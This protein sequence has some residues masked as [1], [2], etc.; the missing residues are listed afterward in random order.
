M[1][2]IKGPIYIIVFLYTTET[3]PVTPTAASA[4]PT[5]STSQKTGINLDS[6]IHVACEHDRWNI[7]V[8]MNHLKQLYPGIQ[9]D[10]IYL[11]STTCKG[12][13]ES[14]VLK[15]QQSLQTCSTTETVCF[16]L[17]FFHEAHS[18]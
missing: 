12:V 9:E 6:A 4:I 5:Q 17:Y 2:L 7:S 3:R 13:T 1:S 8:D 11:G 16:Q 14:G 10:N 18:T 15:F